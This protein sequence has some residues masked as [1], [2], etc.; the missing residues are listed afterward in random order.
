MHDHRAHLQARL[1]AE[2]DKRDT[3]AQL[4]R[5][6]LI[7]REFAKGSKLFSKLVMSQHTANVGA[8]TMLTDSQGHSTIEPKKLGEIML[9][10]YQ[11]LLGPRDHISSTFETMDDETRVASAAQCLGG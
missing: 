1:K 11:H 9:E 4:Q 5:K 3:L 6:R 7:N 10:H 8:P 2:E